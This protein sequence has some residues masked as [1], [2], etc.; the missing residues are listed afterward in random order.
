MLVK[1]T[2]VSFS[3]FF[4]MKKTNIK[5]PS[6]RLTIWMDHEIVFTSFQQGIILIPL[7]RT[8]CTFILSEENIITSP[9]L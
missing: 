3:L 1:V 2:I 5:Q 6:S 9:Y 4:G 7:S 8:A